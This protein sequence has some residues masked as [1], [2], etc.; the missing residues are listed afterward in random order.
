MTIFRRFSLRFDA[1]AADAG[2]AR[3]G[4]DCFQSLKRTLM[5]SRLW[6]LLIASAKSGATEITFTFAESFT[7]CVSIESVMM[8][9]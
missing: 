2:S 7:G 8:S 4:G 5:L 3:I 6:I 9:C 1:V